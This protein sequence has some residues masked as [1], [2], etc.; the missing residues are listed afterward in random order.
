MRVT[1]SRTFSRLLIG[2]G[3]LL[4]GALLCCWALVW[5]NSAVAA[6]R[7]FSV[8]EIEAVKERW[9]GLEVTVEGRWSSYDDQSVRL[10]N[11]TLNF[12]AVQPLPALTRR[13][14]NLEVTGIL[15]KAGE[16]RYEVLV[17]RVR[18]SA[19][20]LDH[21]E[22]LKR[23][24]QRSSA[25]DWYRLADWAAQRGAFYRDN[26]LIKAAQDCRKRGFV[27]ERTRL[28]PKDPVAVMKLA[29]RAA[30]LNLGTMLQWELRH[31]AFW[32]RRESLQRDPEPQAEQQWLEDLVREL[33]GA[34][35]PLSPDEPEFRQRYLTDPYKVYAAA[36]EPERRKIHRVLWSQLTLKTIERGVLADRSNGFEIAHQI[37]E[38]VPEF[39]PRAEELR[40]ASLAAQATQVEHLSK[41]EAIALSAGFHERK[42]PQQG[43]AVIESWLRL[44][45]KKLLPEDIEG[46]MHH[47]QLYTELLNRPEVTRKLLLKLG[48]AH[49]EHPDL[50]LKLEQMGY[51]RLGKQW[52]TQ[53]EFTA[54]VDTRFEQALREGRVEVGMKSGLVLKSLGQPTG[55][56]RV[57]AGEQVHEIW[58]YQTPGADRPLQIFLV[59]RWVEKEGTVVGVDQ[60]DGLMR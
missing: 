48:T 26:E 2:V 11:C 45:E 55:A 29:D 33:P 12:K 19:T 6:G 35:N 14:G 20:D 34:L 36:T 57:S 38:R 40:D 3:P 15:Q 30:E 13:T 28:P 22:D 31:E 59:R 17:E 27:V 54:S 43:D 49:P 46:A 47:A 42:Q 4:R 1:C 5:V 52:I 53:A 23:A 44:R 10:R 8:Q 39:H 37:D 16:K 24:S 7:I 25:N 58:S 50:A 60:L 51:R 18:E 21:F 56:T 41:A 32:L 9:V